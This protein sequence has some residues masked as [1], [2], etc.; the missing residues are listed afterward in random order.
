MIRA[1]DLVLVLAGWAEPA[2]LREPASPPAAKAA[3]LY[4]DTL[5]VRVSDATLCGGPRQIASGPRAGTLVG[6]PH[7]WPFQVRRPTDRPRVPLHTG[8]ADP[9]VVISG[10]GGPQG[11]GPAAPQR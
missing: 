8:A 9:W 4:R 3:T 5:T 10:P 2:P 1:L 6:C 7:T 11:F